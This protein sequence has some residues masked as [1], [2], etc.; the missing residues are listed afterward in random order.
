[1]CACDGTVAKRTLMRVVRETMMVSRW[2]AKSCS[3]VE[4]MNVFGP[5]D[6]L[7]GIPQLTLTMFDM[8]LLVWIVWILSDRPM[9]GSRI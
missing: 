2:S 8:D 6:D 7:C 1:V 9:R 3:F 4:A 5:R